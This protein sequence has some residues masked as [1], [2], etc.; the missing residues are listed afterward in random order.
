MFEC[1][2]VLEKVDKILESELVFWEKSIKIVLIL[3]KLDL[4]NYIIIGI[5]VIYIIKEGEILIRVFLWFYGI[6]DLWFYIVKYNWGVIKNLNNV[7]Y[8]IVFKILE[9]VK[10]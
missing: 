9:L 10:K 7:L 5:K 1:V 2:N 3:V 4:V 6:K 8:G